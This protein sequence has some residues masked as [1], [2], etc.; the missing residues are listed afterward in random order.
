MMNIE[1]INQHS[2]SVSSPFESVGTGLREFKDRNLLEVERG[3][4]VPNLSLKQPTRTGGGE[5]QTLV[6]SA[7]RCTG[8]VKWFN[9]TKGF[10][11]ITPDS[12]T[13]DVF[14]HQSEIQLSGFRSLAQGE[15]VEY[16]LY[17]GEK[18][19]KALKVTGPNGTQVKGAP[20]QTKSKVE[21]K[22]FSPENKTSTSPA[23]FIKFGNG[24][25]QVASNTQVP[26]STP[27]LAPTQITT[28]IP[29]MYST[30]TPTASFPHYILTNTSLPQQITPFD[31]TAM[32]MSPTP[33]VL[34]QAS[35]LPMSPPAHYFPVT[36]L[37]MNPS[38]PLT[39]VGMSPSTPTPQFAYTGPTKAPMQMSFVTS[40]QV[41]YSQFNSENPFELTNSFYNPN[42]EHLS[43]SMDIASPIMS[44]LHG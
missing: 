8:I 19:P 14:V 31:M 2:L 32:P 15:P 30:P 42:N 1:N 29:T 37:G 21:T 33:M 35:H 23:R 20:R 3:E 9:P 24:F 34:E 4:G 26:V 44:P 13:I 10:G 7:S 41:D 17:D 36:Q 40:P 18:G 22:S 25:I 16:H 39:Q 28:T 38:A 5:K 12:G 6:T 11:F 27:V 43:M